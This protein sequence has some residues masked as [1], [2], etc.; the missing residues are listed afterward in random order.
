MVFGNAAEAEALLGE[1]P[2]L[3]D[4]S[5]TPVLVAQTTQNI[6]EWENTKKFT[7]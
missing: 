3:T 6:I 7:I 4:G 5:L 1:D 2:T